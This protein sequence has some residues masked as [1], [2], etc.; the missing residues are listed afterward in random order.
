MLMLCFENEEAFI[1]MGLDMSDVRTEEPRHR[2]ISKGLCDFVLS[3][4]MYRSWSLAIYEAET[5]I[6]SELRSES[7]LNRT[8]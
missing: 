1:D 8:V 4:A 5:V 2:I 6:A 3:M 7:D